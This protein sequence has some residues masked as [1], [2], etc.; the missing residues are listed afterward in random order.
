M[1]D[2]RR[3]SGRSGVVEAKSA[4]RARRTGRSAQRDLPGWAGPVGPAGWPVRAAVPVGAGAVSASASPM[5]RRRCALSCGGSWESPP[6]LPV[7][8]H[9]GD[10]LAAMETPG[11]LR[12]DVPRRDSDAGQ[13]RCG[14]TRVLA[15]PDVAGPRRVVGI[16]TVDLGEYV[17]AALR[18][19]VCGL[20]TVL[21]RVALRRCS[22]RG[23]RGHADQPADHRAAP[24]PPHRQAGSLW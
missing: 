5:A 13:R 10:G 9:A 11:R 20:H 4:C 22:G 24:V 6:E 8:G 23:G 16:T 18:N 14:V 21:G 17:H 15:G 19:G 1:P 7:A 12:P 2:G 3:V